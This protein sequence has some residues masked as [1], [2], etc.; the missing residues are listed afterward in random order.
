M[1]RYENRQSDPL[2]PEK[3]N[4]LLHD[5]RIKVEKAFRKGA[6]GDL[7]NKLLR[8]EAVSD[9]YDPHYIFLRDIKIRGYKGELQ[10][11]D[12]EYLLKRARE[13]LSG[14]FSS[15]D[16]QKVASL[17]EIRKMPLP[18][19][20]HALVTFREALVEGSETWAECRVIIEHFLEYDPDIP[21]EKFY[22]LIEVVEE[23]NQLK[24]GGDILAKSMLAEYRQARQKLLEMRAQYPNNAGLINRFRGLTISPDKV[25]VSVGPLSFDVITDAVTMAQLYNCSLDNTHA[26]IGGFAVSGRG[27][28]GFTVNLR[29]AHLFGIL[30]HEREHIKN[31]R[32]F[33][34]FERKLENEFSGPSLER[35]YDTESDP[36]I[37]EIILRK[38]FK[39]AMLLTLR[40]AK[41]ELLAIKKRSRYED[42]YRILTT[43][44]FYNYLAPLKSAPG[45]SGDSIWKRC[46]EEILDKEYKSHL[47]SAEEAFVALIQARPNYTLEAIAILGS[48]DILDWKKTVSRVIEGTEQ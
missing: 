23:S 2:V 8:S 43:S 32:L 36:E 27:L 31:A 15:P 40:R 42:A 48:K 12:I 7:V 18:E 17:D 4:E 13:Y 29:G 11:E 47:K 30:T 45:R 46:V 19:K 1:E 9:I 38:Y 3:E 34:F 5:E 41:D 33:S 16:S 10:T 22:P 25:A 6:S 21:V 37:K 20:K 24:E 35:S 28:P 26:P 14:K 44:P 39:C